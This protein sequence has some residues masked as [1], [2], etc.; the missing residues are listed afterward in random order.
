[1]KARVARLMQRAKITAADVADD[2]HRAVM[3]GEFLVISHDAAKWQHRLKRALPELFY[4][5]VRKAA[6]RWNPRTKEP[7]RT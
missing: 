2:I 6:K 1:M 3:S 5:E 4:R 7:A